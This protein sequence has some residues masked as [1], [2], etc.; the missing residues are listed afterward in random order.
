METK[1]QSLI[2]AVANIMVGCPISLFINILILPMF[3]FTPSFSQNF[4][5]WLIFTI[6][7]LVRSYVMRRTFSKIWAKVNA[8]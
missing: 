7:A 2:E 3:G 1:K 6:V 4:K 5:I 8:K